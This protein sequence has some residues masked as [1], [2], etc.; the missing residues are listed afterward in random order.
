MTKLS[1]APVGVSF[2]FFPPKTAEMEQKLW[3][4]IERLAPLGPRFVSLT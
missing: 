1:P 4:V 2:E 3:Q